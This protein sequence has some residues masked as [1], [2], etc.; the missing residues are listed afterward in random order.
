M[1]RAQNF[2]HI[3]HQLPALEADELYPDLEKLARALVHSGQLRIDAVDAANF[4][5]MSH[6]AR[7]IYAIFSQRELQDPSLQA[8]SF[9][10]MVDF[11]AKDVDDP[12][13]LARQEWN[14]LH[15]ELN[16]LVPITSEQEYQVARMVV[17]AA[18]PAVILLLLWEHVEVFVTFDH[19]VGDMLDIE[20]WQK[21]GRSSGLQS[22]SADAGYAIYI[23]AGGN[24]F[25]TE[26]YFGFGL[27]GRYAM[28]RILVIGGQE[29]G[30]YADIIR[31]SEGRPIARHSADLSG[32]RATDACRSARLQDM[33]CMRTM[34]QRAFRLG[35]QR[36][37]D[38]EERWQFYAKHQPKSWRTRRHRLLAWVKVRLFLL[39]GRSAGLGLLSHLRAEPFK[40]TQIRMFL[41]DMRFNLTPVADAYMRDDPLEEEAIACIEALARVPQQ[42]NKW[43]HEAVKRGWPQLYRLYYGQVTPA[44]IAAWERVSGKRYRIRYRPPRLGTIAWVRRAW[45]RWKWRKRF[46]GSFPKLIVE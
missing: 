2:Y 37:L 23:S 7:N 4:V 28:A 43:G 34:E 14:R 8:R 15:R 32:R 11:F 41:Q 19:T 13:V 12:D 18:H 9:Q 17:Q 29:L 26:D 3:A 31:N 33:E 35:L 46:P 44:C 25:L 10:R 27:N 42:A 36:V 5:R 20:S 6:P 40:A 45:R 22:T 1:A 16:K 30:H 24:P 39:A 21:I 38:A